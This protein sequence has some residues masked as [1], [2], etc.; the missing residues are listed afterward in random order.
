LCCRFPDSAFREVYREGREGSEEVNRQEERATDGARPLGRVMKTGTEL[1]LQTQTPFPLPLLAAVIVALLTSLLGCNAEPPFAPVQRIENKAALLYLR[2]HGFAGDAIGQF[3]QNRDGTRA[4]FGER[5]HY[6]SS[7][8]RV[9]TI[10]ARGVEPVVDVG[11]E[12]EFWID[13]GGRLHGV[14]A[15]CDRSK[16]PGVRVDRQSGYFFV[17]DADRSVYVGHVLGSD[18]LYSAPLPE[19]FWPSYIQAVGDNTFLLFA[20]KDGNQASL[21]ESHDNVLILRPAPDAP[22]RCSTEIRRLDGR[23]WCVDPTGENILYVSY[24]TFIPL[25]SAAHLY[26]IKSGKS[27]MVGGVGGNPKAPPLLFMLRDDFLTPL[28][29]RS[30]R[31]PSG[32]AGAG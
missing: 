3:W 10:S 26:N 18:W 14:P 31:P 23:P 11:D 7:P 28:I 13:D 21:F 20:I 6:W 27:R 5:S 30:A 2:S 1:M 25:P 16:F 29:D 4:Y 22:G 8:G 32:G 24:S 15:F 12:S 17:V 19:G 9:W